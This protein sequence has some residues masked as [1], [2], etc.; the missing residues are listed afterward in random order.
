M[1]KTEVSSKRFEDV[2][3]F[4]G[5]LYGPDLHAKQVD[6]LAGATSGVMTG[7]SLAMAMVGRALAQARGLVTKHS[8]QAG[9][10]ADE[11]RRQRRV[12]QLCL[13]GAATG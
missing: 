3:G 8:G 13:L 4:I 2:R 7:V 6:A 10:P 1:V 9:R 5:G 12:G 11:Q